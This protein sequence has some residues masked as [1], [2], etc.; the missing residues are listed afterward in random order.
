MKF[1]NGRE[2]SVPTLSDGSEIA[3]SGNEKANMLNKFFVTCFNTTFPPLSPSTSQPL[4]TPV[5]V[6]S[7][8]PQG[9]ALGPLLFLI[10]VNDLP[11]AVIHPSAI[12]NLF[13][14]DV[15]L[16]HIVSNIS[17]FLEVQESINSVERWS[18]SN[19]LNFSF[20]KYKC[21]LISRKKQS[22]YNQLTHCY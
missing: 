19:Y 3:C 22:L 10:Y 14:D 21:M 8:V 12:V 2:K 13:A 15:L 1:L 11:D 20:L 4:S 7:G 9:S 18:S 16:Y 17:D 5:S 6:L